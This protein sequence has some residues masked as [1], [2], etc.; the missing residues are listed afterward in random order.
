MQ[1]SPAAS[2]HVQECGHKVA[3]TV[4]GVCIMCMRR[5]AIRKLFKAG[6]DSC[7]LFFKLSKRL[8]CVLFQHVNSVSMLETPLNL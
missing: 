5:L 1:V 6:H 3:R 2:L 8:G 4:S 7:S